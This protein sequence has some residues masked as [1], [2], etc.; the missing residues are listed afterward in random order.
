MC[1]T[2]TEAVSQFTWTYGYKYF[3]RGQGDWNWE[4]PY[5]ETSVEDG[6]ILA[7]RPQYQYAVGMKVHG[8][9]VHAYRTFEHRQP[10]LLVPGFQAMMLGVLGYGTNDLC[11]LVCYVPALDSDRSRASKIAAVPAAAE[12]FLPP[13]VVDFLDTWR[14]KLWP[15]D[16]SHT[17]SSSNFVPS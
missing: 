10:T 6:C 15:N 13:S 17:M 5:Q 1:L 9:G 16:R 12:T 4:S 3:Y 7:A 2:I 8:G 11:S 14:K